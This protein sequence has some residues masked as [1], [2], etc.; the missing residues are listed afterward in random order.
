MIAFLGVIVLALASLQ[1]SAQDAWPSRSVKVVVPSSPG[2]ATDFF[3]R[4]ISQNLALYKN[5]PS[6]R[7]NRSRPH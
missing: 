6:I 1:V 7:R 5:L 3:A 4:L 2:G